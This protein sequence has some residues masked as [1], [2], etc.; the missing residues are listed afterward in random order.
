MYFSEHDLFHV[1]RSPVGNKGVFGKMTLENTELKN[2]KQVYF[3]KDF[4]K[5]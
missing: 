2:V 5:T 1:T 4:S 3:P